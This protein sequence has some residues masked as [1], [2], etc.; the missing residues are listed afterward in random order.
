MCSRFMFVSVVF[1]PQGEK[2]QTQSPKLTVAMAT[3][4]EVYSHERT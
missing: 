3:F 4:K 1:A 2:R